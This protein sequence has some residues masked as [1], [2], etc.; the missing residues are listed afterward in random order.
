MSTLA[1]G[2]D[3]SKAHE[4]PVP[5]WVLEWE[6][7]SGPDMESLRFPAV[8]GGVLAWRGRLWRKVGLKEPVRYNGD[9]EPEDVFTSIEDAFAAQRWHINRL[10]ADALKASYAEEA[11][12]NRAKMGAQ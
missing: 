12:Q 10:S 7:G 2:Y 9:P 8:V 5:V 1:T 4:E 3:Y 11:A 6:S